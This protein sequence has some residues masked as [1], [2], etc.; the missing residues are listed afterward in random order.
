MISD[1]IRNCDRPS[2]T[3]WLISVFFYFFAMD[4]SE[5]RKRTKLV[6]STLLKRGQNEYM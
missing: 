5:Q 3:T 1:A 2:K 4:E 6:K